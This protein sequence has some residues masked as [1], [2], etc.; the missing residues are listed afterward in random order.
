MICIVR[1]QVKP[2]ACFCVVTSCKARITGKFPGCQTQIRS[3]LRGILT[4]EEELIGVFPVGGDWGQNTAVDIRFRP[5]LIAMRLSDLVRSTLRPFLSNLNGPVKCWVPLSQGEM[6]R[7]RKRKGLGST[8]GDKGHGK[9][10][11]KDHA[12]VRGD[13]RR[14]SPKRE[15][16]RARR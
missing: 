3:E 6:S 5:S 8:K 16:S 7:R 10:K 14:K 11:G 1:S 13:A 15:R 2:C 12:K 4:S 9:G